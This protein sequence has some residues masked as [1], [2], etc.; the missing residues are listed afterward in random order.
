MR[1]LLEL[2]KVSAL[3]AIVKKHD[4]LQYNI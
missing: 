1:V 3:I 4:L 2:A